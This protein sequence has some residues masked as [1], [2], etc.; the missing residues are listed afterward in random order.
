MRVVEVVRVMCTGKQVD[1][2]EHAWGFL[3]RCPISPHPSPPPTTHTHKDREESME[4]LRFLI[5]TPLFPLIIVSQ[6]VVLLPCIIASLQISPGEKVHSFSTS[7]V[8]INWIQ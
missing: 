5:L 6:F 1:R 3:L 2:A 4:D 8:L 7:K